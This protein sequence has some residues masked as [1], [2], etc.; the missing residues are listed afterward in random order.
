MARKKSRQ[1]NNSI[2]I[3]PGKAYPL[4]ATSDEEGVNFALFS[5]NASKVELCLFDRENGK[6]EVRIQMPERTQQVWHVYL[7]D[8]QPGQLY[9]YR[10]HGPYEP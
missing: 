7:P 2:R 9:G 8:V 3:W 6:D 10:V 4:G 5:E 1:K